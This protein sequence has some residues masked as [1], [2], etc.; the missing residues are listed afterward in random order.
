MKKI[1]VTLSI[2]MC[3]MVMSWGQNSKVTSGVVAFQ[4]GDYDKAL[5]TL[6]TALENKD[7]LKK[8]NQP[9]AFY[10]RAKTKMQLFQKAAQEQN[11][12]YLESNN[13]IEVYNDFKAAEK[14]DEAE[15]W[16]KK[17]EL[18]YLLIKPM[19]TQMGMTLVQQKQYDEA[20]KYLS[21]S[22][23]IEEDYI[24]Y[25]LLGQ[26]EQQEKHYKKAISYFEKSISL[27]QSNPSN[28][29]DVFI[30]YTYYR[31]AMIHFY[32]SGHYSELEDLYVPTDEDEDAA[33]STVTEGK[34]V[35]EKEYQKIIKS[36]DDYS[37]EIQNKYKEQYLY[38]KDAL[39]KFELDLYMKT[40]DK[41]DDAIKQFETSLKENPNDY[42]VQ[43]AFASLLEKKDMDKAIAAYE[44]AI[45]IDGRKGEA[46]F[47]L[48]AIYT[49][50]AAEVMKE[51]NEL[52]DYNK[53]GEMEKEAV[54]YLSKSKPYFEKYLEIDPQSLEAIRALKQVTLR[55]GDDEGFMKYK[56]MEQDLRGN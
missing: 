9:K 35:L 3:L 43:I 25:D 23:E 49:N 29:P 15:K 16:K 40:P 45:E 48:G 27:F 44:K 24:V 51:A 53:I 20:W 4:S 10:Y 31:K 34:E 52:D 11:Y 50:K 47:N 2:C 21:A 13:L 17:I 37:E 12:A 6:N 33:F 30:A 42:F 38:A 22:N 8:S 36:K 19:F 56:K 39:N 5:E 55:Q 46:Y 1:V 32:Y 18:D 41:L 14:H 28:N 54:E 7:D 26:I